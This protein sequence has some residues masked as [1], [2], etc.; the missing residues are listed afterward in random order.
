MKSLF[1]LHHENMNVWTSEGLVHVFDSNAGDLEIGLFDSAQK[2][3]SSFYLKYS[4][5]EI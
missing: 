4:N 1:P 3:R 5:E 2:S